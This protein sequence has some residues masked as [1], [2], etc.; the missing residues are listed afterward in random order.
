MAFFLFLQCVYV[1]MQKSEVQFARL[2]IELQEIYEVLGD[3]Y[4][5]AAYQKAARFVDKLVGLPANTKVGELPDGVGK[6]VW[7][8]WIEF[9]RDGR[10][11][12]LDKLRKNRKVMAYRDLCRMLG[13]GPKVAGVWISRGIYGI[14]D[15]RKAVA[16]GVVQLTAVQEL[17]LR[18]YNDMGPLTRKQAEATF[19]MLRDV[20]CKAVDCFE[21]S[22]VGSYR[23]G[24][25]IL[26]DIDIL[27]GCREIS[28]KT[29]ASLVDAL[30]GEHITG[31]ILKGDQRL[32]FLI[33]VSKLHT[34]QVCPHTV[35][36]DILL[37]TQEEWPCALLYFTG[38]KLYNEWMRHVA[39]KQGMLLNQRG[40]YDLH[41]VRIPAHTEEDV[42]RAL[43]LQYEEPSARDY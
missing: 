10:C 43:R 34:V 41:S 39:K 40:L 27:V 35:Q 24:K 16:R 8:K 37:A 14:D 7:A 9:Q 32:S 12:E 33:K 13:V 38:S 6:S 25:K 19:G 15:L 31:W 22:L 36:V 3:S 23:R 20:I 4:R 26:G 21:V 17:G 28:Q 18:H 29:R 2:L 11:A 30:E 42:F 1:A 5:S